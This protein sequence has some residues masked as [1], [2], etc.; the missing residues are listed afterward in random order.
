MIFID[1]LLL[2]GPARLSRGSPP[3]TH[4]IDDYPTELKII[5]CG[6][7]ERAGIGCGVLT[8]GVCGCC[9]SLESFSASCPL[10][11]RFHR[12]SGDCGAQV[13]NSRRNGQEA[14]SASATTWR[15]SVSSSSEMES[16]GRN[17]MTLPKVPQVST[18][19]PAVYAAVAIRPASAAS[20]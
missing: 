5:V 8:I 3:Q 15:P 14:A 6:G 17:R 2:V 18:M 12:I 4:S 20:G 16:G 7:P 11:P 1:S 10:S 13:G 19:T 9:A